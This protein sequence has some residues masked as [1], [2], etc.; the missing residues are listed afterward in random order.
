ML[1]S[2][3]ATAALLALLG[4]TAAQA[5]VIVYNN[6]TTLK[7]AFANDGATDTN[8]VTNLVADDIN[9]LK[10]NAG[11]GVTQFTF[12]VF[13]GATVAVTAAVHI[14]FYD[15]QAPGFS[16]GPGNFIGGVDFSPASFTGG[17][18][19]SLFTYTAPTG[20]TV[21][22]IP[23]DDSLWAGVTFDA[24]G[25]STT[26][27]NLNL[28]GQGLYNPATIGGSD[29][30][31]FIS[32]NPGLFSSSNPGGASTYSFGA[33]GPVA[34]FGWKFQIAAAPEPSA[35]MGLLVG[36]LGLSLLGLRAYKRRLDDA[37]GEPA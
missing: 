19:I 14:R 7:S 25:L 15:D 11:R 10:G 31:F 32:D 34:N 27:A 36:G 24:V 1:K 13:N 22:N 33:G 21:F 6:T 29:N 3:A 20:T 30:R 23:S 2:L 8:L 16:G 5:Q 4:T 18:S 28:L 26:A 12:S 37:F 35:W 17:N 9:P